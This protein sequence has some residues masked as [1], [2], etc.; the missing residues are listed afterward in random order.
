MKKIIFLLLSGLLI[1]NVISCKQEQN[2][3]SE[4]KKFEKT[5]EIAKERNNELFGIFNK[6]IGPEETD[7]L[8]FLYAYMPL[9]DLADYNGDFFLNHVKVSLKAK[10]EIEWSKKI[11]ENIYKH[12]VLPYRVNNENLDTSRVVFYNALKNRVKGLSMYDAAIEVNHWC[13]EKVEYRPADGRTSS[14]LATVKTAYGRCGEESTFTV[15]AMRAV[16]IPARQVYTPRWAHSDDN[17]AWVEV[18]ADGKWYFLGACEPE[19]VLNFGW[20]NE[21]ASRAMLVHARVFGEYEGKEEINISTSQYDDINVTERYANTFKQYVKVVD[22]KGNAVKNASVEYQLYNYAEFYPITKKQTDKN[23]LSFLTTGLGE[24]L[25][26]VRDSAHYGFQRVIIGKKDTVVIAMNNPRL[27]DTYWELM[28]PPASDKTKVEL[29]DEQINLNKIKLQQEDSIRNAYVSTFISKDDFTKNHDQIFWKYVKSSRG[30]Y[31][32]IINFIDI[33]K[34]NKWTESL[35]KVIAA[36]DLRDTKSSILDDH[37]RNSMKYAENFSSDIFEKYIL[38]PRVELEMLLPYKSF[39]LNKFDAAFI[40]KVKQDP[41]K[42]IRWIKDSIK[43]DNE[44]Q[45]YDLPIT[46]VGVYN[47]KVS[48]MRSRKLFFVAVCRSFGIPARLE[49]GT[50]TAQYLSDNKWV[51]VFFNGKPEEYKKFNIAFNVVNKDLK[52]TP[53]YYHHLTLAR[54]ENNRFN[55]LDFGEYK[56]I[57]EIKDIKLRA[58]TYRLI[59]SNRLSSGKILV[60]MKILN[61]GSDT[62]LNL[63]FPQRNIEMKVLGSI[64]RKKI[65]ESIHY[66]DSRAKDLQESSDI[67]VAIIQPDKEPSKHVL[68]DIQI[69]KNDFEKLNN[70]I[71]FIIQKKDL[72]ATFRIEDYPDLPYRTFFII[73]DQDPNKLFDIKLKEK[74]GIYPKVM[75]ASP[76][77]KIYYLEEGYKIGVGNDLLN[78]L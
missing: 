54:F 74:A 39:F 42:L 52:F 22:N 9:N 35:L 48:D 45:A 78:L 12:F 23:G 51:D 76:E 73:T 75:I 6:K 5:R 58:G 33:Q 65:S 25:I 38:N 15:A 56:N 71:V 47:L 61:I 53:Q 46:P 26:W 70:T 43:I 59:T 7:Y 77:G 1:I 28:P 14:P 24:L 44:R 18:W 55:T 11:P 20:F 40:K 69:I 3:N 50:N 63:D 37:L 72:S 64:N 67:V 60:N 36:K 30:N 41:N 32:E 16:C 27:K 8:K 13:H 17:H 66:K 57:D 34:D 29:T 2:T 19:P 4:N 49:P 68:N 62:V 21:S 31:K 10:N